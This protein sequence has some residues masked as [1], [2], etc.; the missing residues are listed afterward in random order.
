MS[1]SPRKY[2]PAVHKKQHIDSPPLII[3]DAFSSFH[4]PLHY[5]PKFGEY[6]IHLGFDGMMG[7]SVADPGGG[8]G[9]I[10]RGPPPFFGRFFNL[11]S[12]AASR[13]LDSRPPPLFTDPGSASGFNLAVGHSEG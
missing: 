6:Y 13:N 9:R 11:F 10:G 12:G 3:I 1:V 5:S 8:G 2:C 7:I 4:L